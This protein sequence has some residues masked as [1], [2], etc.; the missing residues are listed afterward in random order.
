MDGRRGNPGMVRREAESPG[1]RMRTRPAEGISS[2]SDVG[3]QQANLVPGRDGDAKGRGDGC[4]TRGSGP[5][6]R[7]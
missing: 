5:S 1:Q 4:D 3:S 7:E 2:E 6:P